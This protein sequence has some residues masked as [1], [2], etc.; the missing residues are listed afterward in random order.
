MLT[1]ELVKELFD[2][3]DGKLIWKNVLHGSR[4]ALIGKEAS[5]TNNYGYKTVSVACHRHLVHRIIF[6]YH[7]GFLPK[8]I[9]HADGNRI[10]N[11]IENLRVCNR[12]ENNANSKLRKNNTSGFK[13]ICWSKRDR[14]WEAKINANKKTFHLGMFDDLEVAAQI[15]RIARIQHHGEFANTG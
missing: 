15:V 12:S 3:V 14:T 10:N 11:R 2:Y 8:E 1:Q 4:K 7:H 5:C 6:L 13:G 9:D